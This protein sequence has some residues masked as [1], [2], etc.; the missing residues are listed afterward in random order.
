M[1]KKIEKE[2]FD[3]TLNFKN[4]KL[5]REKKKKKYGKINFANNIFNIS[6]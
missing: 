6:I 4:E 2:E 1:L 5:A 3:K